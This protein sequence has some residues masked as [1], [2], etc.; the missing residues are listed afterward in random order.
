MTGHPFKVRKVTSGYSGGESFVV[1]RNPGG[2]RVSVH[3]MSQEQ[4]QADAD[5]LNIG[6]MVR[7]HAEDSRP[8][9]ERLAEAEVSYRMEQGR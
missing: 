6:A 3:S 1:V 5:G 7:P 4:A 2:R 8:Y 9:A